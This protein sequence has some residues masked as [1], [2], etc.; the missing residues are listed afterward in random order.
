LIA[1]GA[2][3]SEEETFRNYAL[4]SARRAAGPSAPVLPMRGYDS[5]FRAYNDILDTVAWEP[6]FEGVV[7]MHQDVEITDPEF[8]HK[9]RRRLA[10]P[11]VGVLGVIGGKGIHSIAWWL[12]DEPYGEVG[13]N[14]LSPDEEHRRELFNPELFR[15][16]STPGPADV[17][18]VDGLLLA[19]SPWAAQNLRFDESLGPGFHGYDVDICFQALHHAKRV[20]IEPLDVIH[21]HNPL[22]MPDRR[23][24]M[25][26]Q[27]AFAAKW[28][29]YGHDF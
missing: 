26:A 15:L 22:T 28:A 20:V 9:V 3:V 27:I 1:F 12:C 13:W 8:L 24:W 21:H 16:A 10:E 23:P 17:D 18:A 4:A 6:G 7:L 25:R 11:G 2:A 14:W 5:I 19:L 29:A